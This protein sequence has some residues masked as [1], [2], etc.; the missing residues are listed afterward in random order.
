MKRNLIVLG[1]IMVVSLVSF[2]TI[3]SNTL[4]TNQPVIVEIEEDL[5]VIDQQSTR[6][7]MDFIITTD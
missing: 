6:R 1:F 5:T 4:E 7:D 3:K 2:Q